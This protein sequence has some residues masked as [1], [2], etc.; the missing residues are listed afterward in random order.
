MNQQEEL[1]TLMAHAEDMQK[2]ANTTLIVSKN[3]TENLTKDTKEIL[4]NIINEVHKTTQTQVTQATKLFLGSFVVFF[5]ALA[6]LFYFSALWT[7]EER[8]KLTV[9]RNRLQK[10]CNELQ[11]KIDKLDYTK[12]KYAQIT[13]VTGQKGFFVYIDPKFEPVNL[14]GGGRVAKL[15]PLK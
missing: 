15:L 2:I 9:E 5:L 14:Q 12:Q 11:N 1:Y 7:Y 6:G 4:Q 3:A 8:D 10:E 13:E